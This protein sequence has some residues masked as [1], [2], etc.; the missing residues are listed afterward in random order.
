MESTL[1]EKSACEHHAF[2]GVECSGPAEFVLWRHNK[3]QVIC[4]AFAQHIWRIG[5]TGCFECRGRRRI[6]DCW[7]T[8]EI[9]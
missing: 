8:E 9:R 2:I 5:R 7:T 4:R 3:R 6:V 1:T